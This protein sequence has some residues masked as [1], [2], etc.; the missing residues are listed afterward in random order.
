LFSGNNHKKHEHKNVERSSSKIN[1]SFEPNRRRDNRINEVSVSHE[2][3][4]RK[5]RPIEPK[6]HHNITE[7]IDRVPKTEKFDYREEY[8]DDYYNYEFKGRNSSRNQR[9]NRNN[10]ANSN[11]NSYSNT[12]MSS[13]SNN[14]VESNKP[15]PKHDNPKQRNYASNKPQHNRYQYEQQIP[16]R[17]LKKQQLLKQALLLL[18]LK[19]LVIS[20]FVH[21]ALSYQNFLIKKILIF[22]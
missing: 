12:G 4:S 21:L 2:E 6:I 8:D 16:P 20:F 9:H 22:F 1:D 11:T 15:R 19:L 18:I 10:S 7:N 17:F 3:N 5:T 14:Y 13:N